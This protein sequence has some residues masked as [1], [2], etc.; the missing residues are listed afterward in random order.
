ML[1]TIRETKFR[2]LRGWVVL[3]SAQHAEKT[4]LHMR[5]PNRRFE[6]QFVGDG[7]LAPELP[8]EFGIRSR[9]D[10]FMSPQ[11]LD[12]LSA[13]FGIP[14]EALGIKDVI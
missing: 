14:M 10:A 2:S 11:V 8:D 9:A 1:L 13:P 12:L 3:G 5:W 4:V 7:L 6:L